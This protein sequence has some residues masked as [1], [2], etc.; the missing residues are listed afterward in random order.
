M[1]HRLLVGPSQWWDRS[2][3]VTS[4]VGVDLALRARISLPKLSRVMAVT[5]GHDA[6][7][8]SEDPGGPD[9]DGRVL[10]GHSPLTPSEQRRLRIVDILAARW[11]FGEGPC[12]RRAL[13]A[14][15]VLRRLHPRLSLGVARRPD[16][17][18]TAHA[19]LELD[20]GARLGYSDAY[21]RMRS[22][23]E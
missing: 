9:A 2:V 3:I 4:W 17:E 18:I 8:S 22:I 16:G 5:L 7:P 10:G 6:A 14:G 19:W 11:P 15:R 1:R 12:L 13:V 23:G 21:H 20:G